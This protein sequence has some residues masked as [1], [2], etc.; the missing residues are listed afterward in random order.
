MNNWEN[1]KSLN[2]DQ[3]CIV[4]VTE[5]ESGCTFKGFV[6]YLDA[7]GIIWYSPPNITAANACMIVECIG[8]AENKRKWWVLEIVVMHLRVA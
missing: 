7:I 8:L 4:L 3:M 6:K 1:F 5:F 2:S